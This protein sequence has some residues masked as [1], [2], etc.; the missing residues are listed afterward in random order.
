MVTAS[1]LGTAHDAALNGCQ[2]QTVL[3]N[4]T[5]TSAWQQQQQQ[6]QQ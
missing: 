1:E 3:Y 2:R 6:Q 5:Q 4:Q